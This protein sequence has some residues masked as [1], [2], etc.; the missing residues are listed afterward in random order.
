M[1]KYFTLLLSA[2][3][4][5]SLSPFL[6]PF[7]CSP[8]IFF[9]QPHHDGKLLEATISQLNRLNNEHAKNGVKTLP[10]R[11]ARKVCDSS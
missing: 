4:V 2:P 10:Y 3:S 6:L 5:F 1:N 11:W 9:L 8:H 7:L